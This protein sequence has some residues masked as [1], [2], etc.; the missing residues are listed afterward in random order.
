MNSPER[1]KLVNLSDDMKEVVRIIGEENTKKL[2]Y[3]FGGSY[4]YIP[5]PQ[6]IDREKRNQLIIREHK[7]GH[8]LKQLAAKYGLTDASIRNIVKYGKNFV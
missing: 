5:I 7:Q 6:T 4:L 8:S 2:L 3:H 1:V